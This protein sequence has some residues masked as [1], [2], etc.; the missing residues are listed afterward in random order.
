MS[1]PA[2]IMK[3]TYCTHGFP[4]LLCNACASRTACMHG[5][6]GDCLLCSMQ[7][8]GF[9]PSKPAKP[10]M[11][12]AAAALVLGVNERYRPGI[13]LAAQRTGLDPAAIAAIINAEAAPLSD[14]KMREKLTDEAFRANHTDRDWDKNPLSSKTPADAALIKEWKQL[15]AS[16]AWDERSYN[17]LSGA[18]GLTQ[19]LASTW[20]FEAKRRGTY[21]NSVAKEKGYIGTDGALVSSTV[22]DL[23]ELRYDPTLS[24][25][26]AAEYDKF[27]FDRVSRETV[28]DVKAVDSVFFARHSTRDFVKQ[29]LNGAK[30][31]ELIKEWKELSRSQPGKPLVPKDLTDDQKARYLYL[32]HHEGESGAIQFLSGSLTDA[33]AQQLLK[34][35]VPDQSKQDALVKEHGSLSKAYIQWLWSYIDSHIQPSGFR[36][37]WRS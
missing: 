37:T 22:N 14:R 3:K 5:M 2:A 24:I 13:L 10:T 16:S 6:S 9:W 23:L 30:D 8:P 31:A 7:S 28:K 1:R 4:P 27:T 36:K 18:A 19:F 33:R 25:V 15:Y 17:T 34:Y 35:N 26:A 11:E 12:A 20:K 32:C 21:L 29:P